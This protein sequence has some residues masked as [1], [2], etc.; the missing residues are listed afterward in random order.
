MLLAIRGIQDMI[1]QTVNGMSMSRSYSY[2]GLSDFSL[3][4]SLV[5]IVGI[6]VH[7]L[8]IIITSEVWAISYCLV[9][10][11]D[12]IVCVECFS[13]LILSKGTQSQ[14]EL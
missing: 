10:G 1:I 13:H 14:F 3:P 11:H 6:Y 12:A 4:I 2:M 5:M 9:P 8:T 7:F